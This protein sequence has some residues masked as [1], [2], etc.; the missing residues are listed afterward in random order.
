[1]GISP[2][3]TYVFTQEKLKTSFFYWWRKRTERAFEVEKAV[4]GKRQR[5]GS[6]D[7]SS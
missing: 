6:V 5:I 2:K 4:R 3:N 1:M 7:S